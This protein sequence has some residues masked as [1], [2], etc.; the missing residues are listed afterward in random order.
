LG[1]NEFSVKITKLLHN[2]NL[3]NVVITDI[4]YHKTTIFFLQKLNILTLGF[5]PLNSNYKDLDVVMPINNDNIFMQLFLFKVII[6]LKKTA[7]YDI[8]S[9][10]R[11]D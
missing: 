3:N 10:Y 9:R 6:F 2:N 11:R 4:F 7:E 5:V 1:R 8:Y